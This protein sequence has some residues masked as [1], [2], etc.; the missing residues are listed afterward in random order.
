MTKDMI[1]A[2]SAKTVDS[3]WTKAKLVAAGVC[4]AAA[5]SH[6][7]MAETPLGER[8]LDAVSGG[9]FQSYWRY[10][11]TPMDV[12]ALLAHIRSQNY[13]YSMHHS[14]AAPA[15]QALETQERSVTAEAVAVGSERASAQA[16][17]SV[18]SPKG[19]VAESSATACCIGDPTTPAQA[20]ADVG[21]DTALD[22]FGVE[23]TVRDTTDAETGTISQWAFIEVRPVAT[24]SHQSFSVTYFAPSSL[25]EGARTVGVQF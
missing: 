9:A 21:P 16:F 15:P 19:A 4:V 10:L 13:S 7:A 20:I 3:L 6:G 8:D 24:T 11:A 5:A 1:I 14:T 25:F 22:R 12:E 23:K 17:A 2:A 18:G